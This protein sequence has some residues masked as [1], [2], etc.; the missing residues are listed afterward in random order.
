MLAENLQGTTLYERMPIQHQHQS[1]HPQGTERQAAVSGLV[2]AQIT[3][4]ETV[5]QHC[6]LAE[7]K[8]QTVASNRI[9]RAGSV[10]DQRDISPPDVFQLAIRCERAS[11]SRG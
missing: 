5:R 1:R 7:R 9:N 2:T 10:T 11:F 3:H 8:T 4:T 6:G